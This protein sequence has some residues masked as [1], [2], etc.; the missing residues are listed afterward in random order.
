VK[1]QQTWLEKAHAKVRQ[2][3]R[4]RG[5]PQIYVDPK[6]FP[7]VA[8]KNTFMQT[9]RP[10]RKWAVEGLIPEGLTILAAGKSVGKTWL[11]LNISLD[12]AEGRPV[13]GKIPA[14]QGPVLYLSL[15]DD[16]TLMEEKL[17]M[18]RGDSPSHG[19]QDDFC[20]M[21]K[22]SGM[23]GD[24]LETLEK[25]AKVYPSTRLIVIDLL[26]KIKPKTVQRGTLYDIEYQLIDAL[27]EV[28]RASKMPIL[29]LHHTNQRSEEQLNDTFDS[30]GGSTGL[31]AP[32]AAVMKLRRK[33]HERGMTLEVSGKGI[34]EHKYTLER[35]E[36]WRI[37]L[38]DE[39]P[40]SR[41]SEERQAII[42]LTQVAT[43]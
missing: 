18:L 11:A 43:Y 24:L 31:L 17:E 38:K 6:L 8:T 42:N 37:W 40:K 4:Q 32:A 39:L 5:I 19:E 9:K 23:D 21:F 28:A 10:P 36:H 35:D 12:I 14:Q 34:K 41:V 15:E 27:V 2:Q 29:L 22:T 13:L 25:W 26:A 1:I 33:R 3:R 7:Q 16:E 20:L 30:V